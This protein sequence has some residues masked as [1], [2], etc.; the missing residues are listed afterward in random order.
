MGQTQSATIP[1]KQEILARTK[2]GSSLVSELFQ[3][4][5]SQANIRDFYLMA[6]PTYC[7]KYVMLTADVLSKVF[8]KIDVVPKEGPKGTI[9]FRKIDTLNPQDKS[10][11]LYKHRE[12]NCLRLAFLYVR[13]FQ[14]FAA[15]SLTIL[16]VD[17]EMEQKLI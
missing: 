1:S 10:D 12:I 7:K 5:V 3:W 11:P 4:M 2:G 8:Y 14:V 13:I 17:P 6:N 16:D 15:L 9:Y